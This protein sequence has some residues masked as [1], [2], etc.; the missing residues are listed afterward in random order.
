MEAF[1]ADE[2]DISVAFISQLG[3]LD[4]AGFNRSKNKEWGIKKKNWMN[5][6]INEFQIR[7]LKIL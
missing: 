5:T 3:I 2:Q 7:H 1:S 6:K 4:Q